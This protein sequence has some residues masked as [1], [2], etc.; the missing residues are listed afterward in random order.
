[1]Q[2]G[3]A[4]MASRSTWSGPGDPT[5]LESRGRFEWE[6]DVHSGGLQ[7]LVGCWTQ[8][9][10]LQWTGVIQSKGM[11]SR[12]FRAVLQWTRALKW[13]CGTGAANDSCDNASP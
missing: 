4:S 10:G 5:C 11:R 12:G 2:F 1:M 13:S 9:S 3:G 8:Y 7:D 6:Q